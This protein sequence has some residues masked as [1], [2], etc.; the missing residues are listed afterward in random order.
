M[1]D[2]PAFP[3]QEKAAVL[4]Y[5]KIEKKKNSNAIIFHNIA[6]FVKVNAPFVSRRDFF[7]KNIILLIPHLYIDIRNIKTHMK[8][9]LGK[10]GIYSRLFKFCPHTFRERY[11]IMRI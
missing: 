10:S 4:K 3:S 9:Q 5:I 2:N 7:K 11:N 1:M 6:D 8:I